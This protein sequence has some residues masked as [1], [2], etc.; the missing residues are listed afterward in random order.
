MLSPKYNILDLR[1]WFKMALCTEAISTEFF[2][3]GHIYRRVKV[4]L[5]TII[6]IRIKAPTACFLYSPPLLRENR[7]LTLHPHHPYPYQ[8]GRSCKARWAIAVCAR[9]NCFF[10]YASACASRLCTSHHKGADS[11][12]RALFP[13]K[14]IFGRG[15]V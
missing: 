15:I 3:L 10:V 7:P 9:C 11:A 13:R 2:L 1:H 6:G 14:T 8:G 5:S 4:L 12:G